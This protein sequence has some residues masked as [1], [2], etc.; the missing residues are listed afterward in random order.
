MENGKWIEASI[1]YS[2]FTIDHSP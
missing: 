1:I 2:P